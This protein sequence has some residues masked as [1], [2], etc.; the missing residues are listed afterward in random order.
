[1]IN[2]QWKENGKI[3]YENFLSDIMV[4][5]FCNKLKSRGCTDIEITRL[6]G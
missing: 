4:E 1:M 6:E 5:D 3:R 2:V